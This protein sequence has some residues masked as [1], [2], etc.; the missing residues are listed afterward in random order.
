[1]HFALRILIAALAVF[2]F[3][4]QPEIGD[5]CSNAS[6]CS[7]QDQRTC[8]TTFPGGY[9]TVFGCGADTCPDESTCIGF[10]SVLSIAPE[11]ADIAV[12]PRLQRTACMFSCSRDSDCRGGY[13]CVD[14]A[15]A[16]P[17]GAVVIE[18]SGAGRVC[19]LLPPALPEGETGVCEYGTLDPP[20]PVDGGSDADSAP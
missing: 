16:N 17:W 3:A 6:D 9:C 14:V 5:S 15:A 19:A 13:V 18:A 2:A 8:D 11:C 20:P 10:Q 4:C 7:V 1:V 12:R